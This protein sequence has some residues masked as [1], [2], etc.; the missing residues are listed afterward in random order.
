MT[1][2]LKIIKIRDDSFD[3]VV[4]GDVVTGGTRDY[5]MSLNTS[6]PKDSPSY[7]SATDSELEFSVTA[8]NFVSN[9]AGNTYIAYL[10]ASVPGISKV[11]S[12]TGNGSTTD[13]EV[14]CG[15]TAGARWVLIKATNDTGD[16]LMT[17]PTSALNFMIKL[18]TNDAMVGVYGI[19][20]T[21]NGFKVGGGTASPS[22]NASGVEYI[23]YAIA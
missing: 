10:F 19:T 14:D 6:G 20:A 1:P 12:Y 21:A 2:E 7:W 5:K 3:W 11:G 15:F 16:W 18:N 8:S 22:T 13:V 9:A 17:T 23:F 4:G